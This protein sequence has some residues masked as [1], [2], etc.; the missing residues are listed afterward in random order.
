MSG[1]RVPLAGCVSMDRIT[2]DITD[3]PDIELGAEVELWGE[4]I[5]VDE[6]AQQAGTIAYE[7]FCNLAP[8]VARVWS[9]K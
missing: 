2:I 8:R 1:G 7:L 9:D 4:Q 5:S 6:V 3:R